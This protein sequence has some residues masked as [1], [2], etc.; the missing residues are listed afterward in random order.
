MQQAGI[1]RQ[2]NLQF[3]CQLKQAAPL[4]ESLWE[5]ARILDSHIPQRNDDQAKESIAMRLRDFLKK[6]R[7]DIDAHIKKRVPN[8]K[9]LNDDERHEWLLNDETLYR[10]A[11]AKGVK[12]LLALSLTS[13]TA[14]PAWASSQPHSLASTIGGAVGILLAGLLYGWWSS[15]KNETKKD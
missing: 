14:S 1:G 13:V 12:L 11:R 9:P 2:A 8:V 4:E 7:N 10:F 15:R 6:Y 5:P 3:P